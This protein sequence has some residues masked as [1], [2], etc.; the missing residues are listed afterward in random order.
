MGKSKKRSSGKAMSASKAKMQNNKAASSAKTGI[1]AKR[2][3]AYA[4][5]W[6]F[7]GVLIGFPEVLVF[8]L[9]THSSDMFSDLYVFGS[10]G[11]SNIYA[12][13]CCVASLAVF[14]AY[15]IWVPLK[16]WPGQTPGKRLLKLRC[17]SRDGGDL[18]PWQYALRAGV[19]LLVIEGVSTVATRY[20]LQALTLATSFY[21][22]G[23]V[24]PVLYLLTLVSGIM[25]VA[26][27]RHLAIH[28]YLAGTR[29]VEIHDVA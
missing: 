20:V 4:I 2:L 6:A 10:M 28:D 19:G 12:F 26:T 1:P 29:V 24:L 11:Y 9:V 3:I 5:D 25:V 15:Y 7:S 13:M 17:E 18:Q 27:K 16:I 14:A 22:E 8:A 23:T 21:V